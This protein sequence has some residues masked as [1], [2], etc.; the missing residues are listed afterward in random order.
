[1]RWNE[2]PEGASLAMSRDTAMEMRAGKPKAFMYGM[3]C[4]AVCVLAL[5]SCGGSDDN[6]TDK[7]KPGPSVTSTHKP[8]NR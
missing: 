3:V 7:P 5:Q 4:G 1:M 6:S 2:V 8:N